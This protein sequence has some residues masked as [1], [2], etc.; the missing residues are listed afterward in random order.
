MKLTLKELSDY[1]DWRKVCTVLGLNYW[2]LNEGADPNSEIEISE[3]QAKE[4]G[5]IK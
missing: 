5:I 4:I 1:Y 3:P 2:C